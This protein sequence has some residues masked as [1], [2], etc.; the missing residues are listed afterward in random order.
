MFENCLG[1]E[2]VI[3]RLSAE[4]KS[5][6]LPSSLLFVGAEASGRLTAAFEL[7]RVL[8]CREKGKWGCPC[9][10]CAEHWLLASNS[11]LLLGKRNVLPE[12][13]AHLQLALRSSGEEASQ[14][15]RILILR[16]VH[17]L[18]APFNPALAPVN[19]SVLKKVASEL[20]RLKELLAPIYHQPLLNSITVTES[21]QQQVAALAEKVQAAVPPG[22]SVEAIRSLRQWA[23]TSGH[24][25]RTVIIDG[26][27][28]LNPSAA[29]SLLKIL[30]EPPKN[31]FFPTAFA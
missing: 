22:V 7:S 2:R 24:E 29:N 28:T 31:L 12:L 5:G 25:V 16:S 21:W 9:P 4:V 19:D 18:I 26:A 3:K 15:A 13:Q 6:S 20:E 27:E 17:K 30:E 11:V 10:S 14:Y 1:H 8:M 23:W